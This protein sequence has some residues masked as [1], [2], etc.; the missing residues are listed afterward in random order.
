MSAYLVETVSGQAS[1]GVQKQK[2]RSGCKL[3][4]PGK[5]VASPPHRFNDLA[6]HRFCDGNGIVNAAPV[7]NNDLIGAILPTGLD[8]F[9]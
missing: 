3:D 6:I 2:Y 1:I 8:G 4:T 9:P 7:A 5:L